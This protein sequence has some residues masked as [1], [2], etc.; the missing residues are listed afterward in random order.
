MNYNCVQ[1]LDKRKSRFPCD[2][3]HNVCSIAEFYRVGVI[4]SA[5]QPGC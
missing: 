3:V 5:D 1:A 2:G 4:K